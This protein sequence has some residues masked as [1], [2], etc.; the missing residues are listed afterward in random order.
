M[1]LQHYCKFF[2]QKS[3]KTLRKAVAYYKVRSPPQVVVSK[4]LF[5]FVF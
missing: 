5:I 4:F 2:M 3:D 1:R